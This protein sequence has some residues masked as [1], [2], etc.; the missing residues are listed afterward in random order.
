MASILF[1]FTNV[2]PVFFYK[3]KHVF[4]KYYSIHLN[5][6]NSKSNYVYGDVIIMLYCINMYNVVLYNYSHV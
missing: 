3:C 6:L 2:Y 4:Y 5:K 1:K